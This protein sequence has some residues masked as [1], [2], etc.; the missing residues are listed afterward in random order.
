MG[1]LFLASGAE[2]LTFIGTG[3]FMSIT[4]LIVVV[5]FSIIGYFSWM[6]LPSDRRLF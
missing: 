4:L 6:R 5:L 1:A 2:L 3:I